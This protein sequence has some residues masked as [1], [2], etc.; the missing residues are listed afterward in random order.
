MVAT[1]LLPSVDQLLGE[2][3]RLRAEN[4]RLRALAFGGHDWQH[5]LGSISRCA[6]CGVRTRNPAAVDV[7]CGEVRRKLADGRRGPRR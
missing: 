2:I 1:R 6:G 4:T 7:S 5:E 3:V